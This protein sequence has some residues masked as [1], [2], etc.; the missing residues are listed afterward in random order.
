MKVFP[1]GTQLT[2]HRVHVTPSRRSLSYR[3]HHILSLQILQLKEDQVQI[4]FHRGTSLQIQSRRRHWHRHCSH[5]FRSATAPPSVDD[6]SGEQ[7]LQIATLDQVGAEGA[8]QGQG[9]AAGAWLAEDAASARHVE[10]GPQESLQAA[11]S[12]QDR[13]A[14]GGGQCVH[15]TRQCAEDGG[16]HSAV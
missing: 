16:C 2:V 3:V 8:V 10:A 1:R 7:A 14:A 6:Q 12:E 5:G 9:G 11:A 15:R 4:F 13:V